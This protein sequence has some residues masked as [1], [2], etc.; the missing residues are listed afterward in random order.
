M[1]IT[2][3]TPCVLALAGTAQLSG[4]YTIDDSLVETRRTR[5][6][7]VPAVVSR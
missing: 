6:R 5:I 2:I 7:P 3:M 4:N 1:A